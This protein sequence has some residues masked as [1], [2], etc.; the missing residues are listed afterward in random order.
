M[1]ENQILTRYAEV[2]STSQRMLDAAREA[3]WDSL[4]EA[5]RECASLIERIRAMGGADALS[6]EARKLRM[7]TIRKILAD[8][9]EIRRLTQPW[10]QKLEALLT[11]CD[12]ER[13]LRDAYR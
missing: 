9:A 3:D 8:D 10:L 1:I 2:A 11:G 13:R 6:P 12:S 5:E 7:S 4:V